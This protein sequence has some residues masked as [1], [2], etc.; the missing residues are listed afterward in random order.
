MPPYSP[1]LNPIEQAVARLKRWISKTASH[2]RDTCIA[3]VLVAQKAWLQNHHGRPRW[4][5]AQRQ[6]ETGLTGAPD[7]EIR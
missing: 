7:V 1:D 3:L 4:Q 6:F 5:V 2:S